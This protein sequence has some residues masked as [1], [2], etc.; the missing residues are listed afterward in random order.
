MIPILPTVL[1]ALRDFRDRNGYDDKQLALA[2]EVTPGTLSR[3]LSGDTKRMKP[4]IWER[5]LGRIGLRQE[6]FD[7]AV[8]I[9]P[10][11][12]DFINYTME[13]EHSTPEEVAEACG[14]SV[15]VV[16]SWLDMT[17]IY[18]RYDIFERYCDYFGGEP[19]AFPV[20]SAETM[21]KRL[22]KEPKTAEERLRQLGEQAHEQGENARTL[23]HVLVIEQKS[24]YEALVGSFTQVT[25]SGK[26]HVARNVKGVG[27]TS[28]VTIDPRD[29]QITDG[30]TAAFM[31]GSQTLIGTVHFVPVLVLGSSGC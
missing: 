22:E 11:V 15:E 24:E 20:V 7:K 9:D 6:D 1:D 19:E 18:I 8:V 13:N 23:D 30:E 17:S 2:L 31:D 25:Y 28:V 4:E 3:W 29:T 16:N 10:M 14:V 27:A 12:E 26:V 5:V 21:A